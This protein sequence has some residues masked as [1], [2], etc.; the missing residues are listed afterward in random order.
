VS[1]SGIS[2]QHPTAQ[3]FTGRMPFLPPNQQCQST[4]LIT[5]KLDLSHKQK[6]TVY[7]SSCKTFCSSRV[8][9]TEEIYRVKL[10]FYIFLFNQHMLH[11]TPGQAGYPQTDVLLIIKNSCNQHSV[12]KSLVRNSKQWHQYEIRNIIQWTLSLWIHQITPNENLII[13]AHNLCLTAMKRLHFSS[14]Y[15]NNYFTEK[16]LGTLSIKMLQK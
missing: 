5:R 16:K 11:S 13:R 1:G 15:A 6:T 8:V 4:R 2:C 14:K 7:Q 9:I 3:F 10:L 12:N